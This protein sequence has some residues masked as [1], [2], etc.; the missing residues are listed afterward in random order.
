MDKLIMVKLVIDCLL[1]LEAGPPNG[2]AVG[3]LQIRPALVE[4]INRV[5]RADGRREWKL[6]QREGKGESINM[7]MEYFELYER[8]EWGPDEYFLLHRLGPTGMKRELSIAE[9][10]DLALFRNLYAAKSK[11]AK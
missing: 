11:E 8:P 5:R 9:K 6:S 7:A 1:Q 3:P 2:D 10:L 4:D